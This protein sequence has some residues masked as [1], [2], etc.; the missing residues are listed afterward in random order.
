MMAQIDANKGKL[1]AFSRNFNWGL[2]FFRENLLLFP[3]GLKLSCLLRHFGAAKAVPF[4]SI[5]EVGFSGDWN[6]RLPPYPVYCRSILARREWPALPGWI[7]AVGIWGLG[8]VE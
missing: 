2:G 5:F 7:C 1:R 8:L 4:Q 3:R 6:P